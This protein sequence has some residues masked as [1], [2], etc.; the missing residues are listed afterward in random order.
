MSVR[1][2]TDGI[3]HGRTEI[4]I[5]ASPAR[6]FEVNL[7]LRPRLNL[8]LLLGCLFVY[9]GCAP[10]HTPSKWGPAIDAFE[11]QDQAHPPPAHPILFVGS[12][13]IRIWKTSQDFPNLPV[14]NRGFG[15]SETSD[16]VQFFDRVVA[17]YQPTT[18]VFYS[19]DNDL[20]AGKSAQRVIADTRQ[21]I[22]LVRTSLP[23]TK[24]I[25]IAI[26]PSIARWK[27]ID[28]IHEVNGQVQHML[29]SDPNAAFVDIGTKLL[30][31][32]GKPDPAFFRKDG[33]H[34]ND[35]GYQ[36]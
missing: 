18:I 31:R 21:F 13:T 7:M 32:D 4:L 11:K 33:L 5:N 12:S 2:K 17:R 9:A 28:K 20:A 1:R 27:L 22:D 35:K 10:V 19:G 8:L 16:V 25:V 34:L 14:L 23:H 15:G 6:F 26:K 30:G 24:L 29:Q 3:L 36:I